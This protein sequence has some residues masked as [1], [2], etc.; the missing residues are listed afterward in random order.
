MARLNQIVD[1]DD[2]FPDLSTILRGPAGAGVNENRTTERASKKRDESGRSPNKRKDHKLIG[3]A[4]EDSIVP[5][6]DNRLLCDEEHESEPQAFGQLRSTDINSLFLRYPKQ[7]LD[8]ETKVHTVATSVR[9]SP[10]RRG[11][12]QVDYS[13]CAPRLSDTS[14]SFSDDDSFTDLSGFIVPDSASDEEVLPSSSQ[15][16]EES[17]RSKTKSRMQPAQDYASNK[18]RSPVEE[19]ES[20]GPIDLTSPKKEKKTP[21]HICSEFPPRFETSPRISERSGYLFDLDE[22]F[23]KLRLCVLFFRHYIRS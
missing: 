12:A 1:S 7:S 2:E 4:R 17:R 22:P 14:L 16:K 18:V 5:G 15:K 21:K 8:K 3:A 13:H 9:T 20:T 23:S 10:R 11:R 19:L 6:N